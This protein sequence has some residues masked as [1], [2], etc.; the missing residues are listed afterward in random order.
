MSLCF[1]EYSGIDDAETECDLDEVTDWD[2][3]I[4]NNGSESELEDGM[5]NILSWINS[6]VNS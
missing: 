1:L 5:Q 4:V 6:A 2:W 3:R